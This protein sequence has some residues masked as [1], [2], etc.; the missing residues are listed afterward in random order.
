[1][2]TSVQFDEKNATLW[3][4]KYGRGPPQRGSRHVNETQHDLLHITSKY[5]RMSANYN[6]SLLICIANHVP[7]G[8]PILRE[9]T[10][11]GTLLACM[12]GPFEELQ[13]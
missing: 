5:A 8:L 11:I 7:R 3:R 9:V 13:L 2:S 12:G 1:M 4:G 6:K 10:H